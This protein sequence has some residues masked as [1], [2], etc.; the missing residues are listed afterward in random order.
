MVS[1]SEIA[2]GRELPISF[3]PEL[4]HYGT[5]S[6]P[7]ADGLGFAGFRLFYDPGNFGEVAAF[8]GASYFR[9]IGQGQVYGTSAR[10]LALDTATPTGEEFPLF[11]K[12]WFVRPARNARALTLFALLESTNA[13]GAFRFLIQPGTATMA[14]VDAVFFSRG[15]VERFGIAPLTSMF[16]H[17]ENSH[18]PFRDFRPEVHDADGLLLH[19]RKDEWLWRPLDGGK[20]LRV[21]S[22]PEELRGFG[23]LQRDR[24]F[25]HYQDLIGKFQRRPSVW[26]TPGKN[27]P[28]G[29]LNLI[30]LPSD[31]E[32]TDNVV[33]FWQPSVLPKP[34]ESLEIN[35]T[36]QW[37]AGEPS[38]ASQ[39]RVRDTRIGRVPT[40]NGR[41]WNLRFVI[42]FDGAAIERLP[43]KP[44]LKAE[45]QCGEGAQ[46]VADTVVKNPIN[47]T[48]RLVIETTEPQK[49]VDLRARLKLN[50]TPVTETW[51]YTFQP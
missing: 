49:P 23:L 12:F 42:D 39:G 10:G 2:D 29:T 37:T 33:A 38:T 51:A 15:S 43:A 35:Y 9:M 27:W 31:I 20:P 7:P 44:A 26:I 40:E 41:P 8:I 46:F 25:E 3:S 32:F 21:S 14:T 47:S 18:I 34:G 1:I 28:D 6:Y 4:F 45:V 19:T 30:Q 13:T 24:N 50:N 17:D 11:T 16:V 22:F 36:M 5:N 48:W